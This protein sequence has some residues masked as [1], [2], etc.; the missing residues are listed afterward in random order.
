VKLW[1]AKTGLLHGNQVVLEALAATNAGEDASAGEPPYLP[2]IW[3]TQNPVSLDSLPN[4]SRW[5]LWPSA[6]SDTDP[7]KPVNRSNL[8]VVIDTVQS[9]Q[10]QL[11]EPLR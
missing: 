5:M 1:T 3:L 7:A 2:L 8:G 6:S 4:G 10:R 11:Q 9:L